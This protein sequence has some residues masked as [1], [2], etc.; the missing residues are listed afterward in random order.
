MPSLKPRVVFHSFH[1]DFVVLTD[2]ADTTPTTSDAPP[3]SYATNNFSIF[4]FFVVVNVHIQLYQKQ[5]PYIAT[6]VSKDFV[7]DRHHR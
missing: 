7:F 3:P 1:F 6:K 4:R 2:P 5:Q